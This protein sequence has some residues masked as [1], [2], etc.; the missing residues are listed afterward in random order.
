MKSFNLPD[1]A[2]CCAWD[3][4]ECTV[5]V[6]FDSEEEMRAFRDALT[7]RH[8]VWVETLETGEKDRE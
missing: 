4:D 7:S 1:T 8:R 2:G 6:A 3:L 5:T